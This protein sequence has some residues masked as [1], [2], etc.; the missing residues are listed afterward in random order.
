[1]TVKLALWWLHM[2]TKKDLSVQEDY[3]PP[4]RKSDDDQG[5]QQSTPA[6]AL[7]LLS[8]AQSTKRTGGKGRGTGKWGR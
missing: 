1:M 5:Q 7:P 4:N 6:R 8:S 2:E 3:P